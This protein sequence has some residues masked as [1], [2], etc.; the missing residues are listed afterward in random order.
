MTGKGTKIPASDL[1]RLSNLTQNTLDTRLLIDSV[2]KISNE[3]QKTPID[4]STPNPK[5]P[6]TVPAPYNPY[7]DMRQRAKD[8]M[9]RC[10]SRYDNYASYI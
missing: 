4:E 1:F 8:I 10:N 3:Q 9:T 6:T 7:T 5:S 2:N